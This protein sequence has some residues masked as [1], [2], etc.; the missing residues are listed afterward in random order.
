MKILT[1]FSSF[2]ILLIGVMSCATTPL[3]IPEKYNLDNDL[4]AVDRITAFSISS[5]QNIDKQS[6]GPQKK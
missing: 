5:Y 2:L 1:K 6:L 3:V 4:E